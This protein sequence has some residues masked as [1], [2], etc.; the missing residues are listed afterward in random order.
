MIDEELRTA[1]EQLGERL[2]SR[3]GLETI[4]LLERHPGQLAAGPGDLV[5]EPG[6]LLLAR[7]Q[8]LASGGPLFA[9]SDLVISQLFL[10]VV[11][12]R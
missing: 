12:T 8:R 4:L 9:G 10:L 11:R 1:V 3:L 6:V 7:E 2:L 5:A